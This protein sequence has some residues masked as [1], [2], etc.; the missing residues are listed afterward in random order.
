MA[1]SNAVGSAIPLGGIG[2]GRACVPHRVASPRRN[3][4]VPTNHLLQ[5]I[6]VA[7]KSIE[8][9]HF[10]VQRSSGHVVFVREPVKTCGT[11]R[12]RSCGNGFDE[13]TCDALPAQEGIDK[14]ILQVTNVLCPHVG[15][16]KKMRE[17][18]QLPIMGCTKAKNAVLREQ[19]LPGLVVFFIWQRG[20]VER[21]IA[22]RKDNR[23]RVIFNLKWGDF[24]SH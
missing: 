4:F 8:L 9:R 10:V 15:V 16:K 12:L 21:F 2:K 18:C 14:Q 1:C 13:R 23:A 19:A 3:T 24:Y 6:V 22:V 20:F 17:A 5:R 7:N 11:A